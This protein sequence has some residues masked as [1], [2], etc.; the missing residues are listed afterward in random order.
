MH[1]LQKNRDQLT[2]DGTPTESGDT[3]ADEPL[4][5]Y[6][7]AQQTLATSSV[8]GGA[9][10]NVRS[11]L[12]GTAK[13]AVNAFCD[14]CAIVL[15]APDG[16]L[17]REAGAHR[18]QSKLEILRKALEIPIAPD[19]PIR[20]V[21]ASGESIIIPRV[22]GD[23][24]VGHLEDA[25]QGALLY[26]LGMR[27]V[28][29]VP[30]KARGAAIGAIGLVSSDPERVFGQRDLRLAE[31]FATRAALQIDNARLFERERQTSRELAF[32]SRVGEVL[33]SSLDTK[34]ALLGSENN[35]RIANN[36]A[37]DLSIK[38]LTRGNATM[39]AMFA[40]SKSESHGE[41]GDSDV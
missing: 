16:T 14:W 33:V 38:K 19:A 9:A 39:I 8:L 7:E 40:E 26:E 27:S 15:I 10:F 22:Q 12:E 3:R 1:F 13:L 25:T 30:L 5:F 34:E 29:I 24:V 31:S 6:S 28:M 36:K 2:Y 11:V 32:L 20:R 18:D 23:E 4:S 37:D 17:V 21:V 35:L 41:V